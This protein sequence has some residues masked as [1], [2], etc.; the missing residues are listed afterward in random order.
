[1]RHFALRL[2]LGLGVATGLNVIHS[3]EAQAC[4]MWRPA[5]ED[6]AERLV[7]SADRA[8]AKGDVRQAVRLYERAMN[9]DESEAGIRV[10]AAIR[11]GDLNAQ[12]G[13][14]RESLRRYQ[15]AVE[16]DG[17]SFAARMALG[18]ALTERGDLPGAQTQFA[19]AGENPRNAKINRAN[20][21]AALAIVFSKQGQGDAAALAMAK[22]RV[23]GAADSALAA[24][25]TAMRAA[26]KPAAATVAT[27]QM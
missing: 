15:H 24:A 16:L 10:R 13:K 25:E 26:Q 12:I 1:M 6:S 11:A 22:A 23:M 27:I 8:A 4:G 19:A 17:R 20:A 21:Q 5:M 9:D 7:A 14:A 18:Q 2:V 3:T